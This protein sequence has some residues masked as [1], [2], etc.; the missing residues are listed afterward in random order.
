M[1]EDEIVSKMLKL[2][3]SLIDI[4]KH[5]IIIEKERYSSWHGCLRP[6]LLCK[7]CGRHG[8][9]DILVILKKM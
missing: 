8:W 6:S 4:Q 3:D 7:G 9:I 1:N 5:F 2:N